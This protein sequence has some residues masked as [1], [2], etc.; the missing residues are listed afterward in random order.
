MGVSLC[1]FQSEKKISLALCASDEATNLHANH[2]IC[3][4][5]ADKLGSLAPN[6]RQK[7]GKRYRL[8]L[9]LSVCTVLASVAFGALEHPSAALNAAPPHRQSCG[10]CEQTGKTTKMYTKLQNLKIFTYFINN[11]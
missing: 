8:A 10:D 9:A 11:Y 1:N 7:C 3:D 5:I 2:R 4:K 6:S